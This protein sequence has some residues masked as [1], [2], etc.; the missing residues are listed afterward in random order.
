MN[1]KVILS[2]DGDECE[3]GT[4]EEVLRQGACGAGRRVSA[5][6]GDVVNA[7]YFNPDCE[8]AEVRIEIR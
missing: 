4:V 6:V 5:F 3:V 7:I 8:S 1:R 2:Y